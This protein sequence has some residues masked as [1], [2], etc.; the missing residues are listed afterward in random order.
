MG[1][2]APASISFLSITV[3]NPWS[4]FPFNSMEEPII[5]QLVKK[6]SAL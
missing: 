6:F 2:G 3:T 1:R 5:A 4:D